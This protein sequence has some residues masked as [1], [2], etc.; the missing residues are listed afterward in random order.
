MPRICKIFLYIEK[1]KFSHKIIYILGKNHLKIRIYR[2]I[3]SLRMSQDFSKGKIYKITNDYN[4]DIY[5]G[6]T[7]DLLT[8]RFSGHKADSKKKEQQN[9]PLIKLINEIGFDRFRIE[10]IEDYPCQ[11]KYQLRQREG[12]FIR[13]IGSLNK[14]IAG[15]ST[16]DYKKKWYEENRENK[17]ERQKE[18]TANNQERI[19]EY[20]KKYKEEHKQKAS[21]YNKKYREK[22]KDK[23]KEYFKEYYLK[24]K[25]TIDIEEVH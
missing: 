23:N 12:H 1:T 21:D 8:K 18:I 13:E 19:I 17:I 7:C 5:V 15:R 11:D 4:D 14:L 3:R 24:N 6:S 16:K 25:K 20:Q 22:N 9:R 10:L 2:I